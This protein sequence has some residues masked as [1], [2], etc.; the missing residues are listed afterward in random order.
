MELKW[1]KRAQ[2]GWRIGLVSLV[3][4]LC[5]CSHHLS[6]E[7]RAVEVTSATS[8][9]SQERLVDDRLETL[10]TQQEALWVLTKQIE[11]E[12]QTTKAETLA[13]QEAHAELFDGKED[14]IDA[15]SIATSPDDLP[16][17]LIL[18]RVEYVQ[19]QGKLTNLKARVDTG[20][21]SSSLSATDIRN[22]ERNGESWVRFNVLVDAQTTQLEAPVERYVRIRQVNSQASERRPEVKLRVKMGQLDQLTPFTLTDRSQMLYPVLLGR[23]FLTD[24]AVVD[25]ALKFTQGKVLLDE[26]VNRKP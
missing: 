10:L 15:T 22:F 5:S 20:A 21:K 8:V 4:L 19:I 18:G 23:S 2:N 13:W 1:S 25:V 16:S 6:P 26:Q 14:H 12:L 17:K 11:L 3:G 24:I 7:E 9:T